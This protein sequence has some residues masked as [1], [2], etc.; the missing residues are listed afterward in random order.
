MYN[1]KN[2]RHQTL[3]SVDID[4]EADNIHDDI[5]VRNHFI[6]DDDED[7]EES[8]EEYVGNTSD[9]Y[10]RHYQDQNLQSQHSRT[11]SPYHYRSQSC[12]ETLQ[13]IASVAGNVLEVRRGYKYIPP[14]QFCEHFYIYPKYR[15]DVVCLVATSFCSNFVSLHFPIYYTHFAILYIFHILILSVVR[16]CCIWILFGYTW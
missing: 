16:F 7:A 12:H 4:Q 10:E 3:S 9:S 14:N 2:H 13:T 5:H 11:Y 8:E 1:R 15:Y 6:D